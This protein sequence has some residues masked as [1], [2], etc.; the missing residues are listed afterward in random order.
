MPK[1]V[2]KRTRSGCLTC[3]DRH[4]KCDEQLPVCQNCIKSQR[5]CYRGV[6]LNFIQYSFYDP[7][8]NEPYS[9]IQ[10]LDQSITIAKLYNGKHF[11]K[12][13]LKLHLPHD[14]ITSDE[15]FQRDNEIAGNIII[16]DDRREKLIGG[17]SAATSAAAASRATAA[18]HETLVDTMTRP[19]ILYDSRSNNEINDDGKEKVINSRDGAVVLGGSNLTIHNDSAKENSELDMNSGG[20]FD[21]EQDF[22]TRSTTSVET[23]LLDEELMAQFHI[24]GPFNI[25]NFLLKPK[26]HMELPPLTNSKLIYD[27][28]CFEFDINK[29]IRLMDVEKYHWLLD[30]FNEL[31]I[32]KSLI[33][34][35]CLNLINNTTAVVD[36]TFLVNCLLNCS[37]DS[38]EDWPQ[39]NYLLN[40]QLQ[41]FNIVKTSIIS[42]E[43][44]R[45]FEI[46]FI[47][48][49]FNLFNLLNKII[50]KINFDKLFMIFNNQ[51]KMFNKL[52][53][54]FFKLSNAKYKKFKSLVFIS[55]IHSIVIL[56]HIIHK[57]LQHQQ[58]EVN[59][60]DKHNDKTDS[61]NTIHQ[62]DNNNSIDS[63]NWFEDLNENISYDHLDYSSIKRLNY[64]EVLHLDT[65]FINL[66]FVQSNESNSIVKTIT[67]SNTCDS[68]KLR[69]LMWHS[70][71]IDYTKMF[72]KFNKFNIDSLSIPKFNL[73]SDTIV[74]TN[75]RLTLIVLMSQYLADTKEG[76]NN[77]K[78][79]FNVI[80]N[81]MINNDIKRLCTS[82]FSWML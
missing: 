17:L 37:K 68:F 12:S 53:F 75:D 79:L 61:E 13:Y 74:F 42:N 78:L 48:I 11:Y 77:L 45:I 43:N 23:P 40:L 16:D 36:N 1:Q 51:I 9:Q 20:D 34:S 71:K 47:S 50:M 14:L 32:W 38:L 8:I 39:F 28:P 4:M 56:K 5:K 49:V 27:N 65:D 15:I 55:S 82:Y 52:V 64:F 57:H 80:E 2:K 81:S 3:R 26:Y 44:F 6:R 70:I 63:L 35:Y 72:A 60:I 29:F 76:L 69:K 24:P 59:H 66:E 18:L 46:L 67:T 21:N 54:K 33:P 41:Y 22:M 62:L 31:N 25:Q 7:K 19:S 30:L 10:I 73:F 58:S